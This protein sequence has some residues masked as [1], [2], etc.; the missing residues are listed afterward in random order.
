MCQRREADLFERLCDALARDAVAP[1]IAK[2]VQKTFRTRVCNPEI[3]GDAQARKYA[4]D[5]EGSLDAEPADLVGR[6]AGDVAAAEK[7]FTGIRPQQAGYQVKKR[8][9]P[10]AIRSNDGVE[11]SALQ[12]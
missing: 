4:F 12:T 8:G 2:R 3:L 9:F 7:D 11:L 6:H 1:G 10:G 5:L